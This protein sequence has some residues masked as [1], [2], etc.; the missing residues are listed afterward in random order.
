MFQSSFE[1]TGYITPTTLLALLEDIVSKLFRAYGLYNGK[2]TVDDN[3]F[4]EFQSSFELTGYITVVSLV[5]IVLLLGFQSSFELTGYIT[6]LI[7]VFIIMV[8]VSKLF[9]A[10]G[11][12]NNRWYH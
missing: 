1:L 10:Y 3:A 8:S 4:L 7:F 12:Y 2:E 5:I 11:L 9:R 6:Y